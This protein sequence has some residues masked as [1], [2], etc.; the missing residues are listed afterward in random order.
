MTVFSEGLAAHFRPR[1]SPPT[2]ATKELG[3]TCAAHIDR[4]PE[5]AP[6]GCNPTPADSPFRL[7]PSCS[8]CPSWI[9]HLASAIHASQPPFPH[10]SSARPK[11]DACSCL[12]P[13]I[14]IPSLSTSPHAGRSK[15]E[16]AKI[17]RRGRNSQSPFPRPT[18]PAKNKNPKTDCRR[19]RIRSSARECPGGPGQGPNAARVATYKRL[20]TKSFQRH[21]LSPFAPRKQRNKAEMGL[22]PSPKRATK[23]NRPKE[24]KESPKTPTSRQSPV[25][26]RRMRPRTA[27]IPP[28]SLLCTLYSVLRTPHFP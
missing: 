2:D 23:R 24:R 14:Y 13:V 8:S 20:I 9:T 26:S 11:N 21:S 5:T 19:R 15:G 25:R 16:G 6:A 22:S 28:A 3:P 17:K 10:P 27:G 7:S 12:P 1:R 4:R 18:S